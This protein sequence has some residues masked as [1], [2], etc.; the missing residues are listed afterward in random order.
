[1]TFFVKVV[2]HDYCSVIMSDIKKEGRSFVVKPLPFYYDDESLFVEE[3][4]ECVVDI[5]SYVAPPVSE[6][7][8]CEEVE[9]T[10]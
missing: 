2:P 9:V 5:V 1:M 6:C 7:G 4:G 8:S 10:L 3:I